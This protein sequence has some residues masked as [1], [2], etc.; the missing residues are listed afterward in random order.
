MAAA[1]QRVLLLED[2]DVTRRGLA[3]LL[4]AEGYEVLVARNA[5]EAQALCADREP[6]VAIV[7]IQL[8]GLRG[9]EWALYLKEMSPDTRIIFVSGRPG[10]AGLDRYGPDVHFLH[11]PF[12][13]EQLLE[14]IASSQIAPLAG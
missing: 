1:P 7:D 14:L 9:D 2:Q 13:P 4:A 6:D 5:L 10:L 3:T 12:A 11:K 8:P